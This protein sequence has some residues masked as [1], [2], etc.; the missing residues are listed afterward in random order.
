MSEEYKNIPPKEIQ[1][2]IWG[3]C[4]DYEDFDTDSNGTDI[5]D[6]VY[7][8][9]QILHIILKKDPDY[10]VEWVKNNEPDMKL[11]I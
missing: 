11:F 1:N 4:F 3:S 7:A 8:C 6:R 2:A 9:W 10:F 5:R